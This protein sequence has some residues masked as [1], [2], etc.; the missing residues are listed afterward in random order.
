M[1]E[2]GML[3]KREWK[4]YFCYGFVFL[5]FFYT[6][7]LVLLGEENKAHAL[8]YFFLF[9]VQIAYHLKLYLV[10]AEAIGQRFSTEQRVFVVKTFYQINN[11][12][13]TCRRF[14]EQFNR[15]T[16]RETVA[17]SV[18][19]FEEN[20]TVDDKKRS[21]RP[22]IVRTVVIFINCILVK[23]GFLLYQITLTLKIVSHTL[24]K[25][26]SSLKCT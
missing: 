15:Q 17:D 9:P 7:V 26:N 4:A 8:I 11:K 14:D 24:N 20:G 23:L 21:D 18:D 6:S 2:R 10:L 1:K 22:I 3:G 5:F 25:K 12:N 16:R 19:R 13:K